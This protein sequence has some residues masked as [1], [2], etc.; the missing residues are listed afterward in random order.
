[1][2]SVNKILTS[3]NLTNNGLKNEGLAL[4]TKGLTTQS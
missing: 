2:L 4:V 3:L 1:M